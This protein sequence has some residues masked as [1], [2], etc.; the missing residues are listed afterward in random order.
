MITRL[1][2]VTPLSMLA[3]LAGCAGVPH[4]V[5]QEQLSP[6][7]AGRT[8][9]DIVVVAV[10]QD[11]TYRISSESAFVEELR[12]QGVL[13]ATSYEAVPQ[14]DS[15]R[16]EAALR[17]MLQSSN[18]DAVLT[19][20]TIDAGYDYGYEDYLETR[21]LVYLLGGE[22]GAGTDMGS[23]ISWAGSGQYHLHIALWDAKTFQPVWQVT[24]ESETTG[25]DTGDIKALAEFL[26]KTLRDRGLLVE[27]G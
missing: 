22:P 10:Y 9:S 15:A 23:F 5:G 16:A 18:H 24:T 20:S 17:G 26:A 19:V 27:A 8:F 2:V 12:Q 25:S 1:S 21:G 6:E 3:F 7:A 14:L 11:R 4:Q 13:A